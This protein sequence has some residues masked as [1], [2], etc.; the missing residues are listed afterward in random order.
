MSNL[1]FKFQ[2]YSDYGIRYKTLYKFDS[3]VSHLDWCDAIVTA[4][5]DGL[6]FI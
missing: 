1:E 3:N 4:G 6:L 5:G 2:L